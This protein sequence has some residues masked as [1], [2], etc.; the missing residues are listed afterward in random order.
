MTDEPKADRRMLEALVCP[1]SQGVL[2]YDAEKQELVSKAAHLAFP[3][4]NG[5][6]I[7]LVDE[8]REIA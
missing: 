3:I 7:M 1:V 2:S 8:A 6:P 5:I 4:R